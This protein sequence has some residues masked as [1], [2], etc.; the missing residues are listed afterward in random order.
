MRH[1][2]KRKYLILSAVLLIVLL[3]PA[4][5]IPAVKRQKA[6]EAAEAVA[7]AEEL[8]RQ[9]EKNAPIV[10]DGKEYMHNAG[11][12]TLLLFGVD[13]SED[14]AENNTFFFNNDLQADFLILFSFDRNARTIKCLHINRDTVTPVMLLG[15][16]GDKIGYADMQ[17]CLAHT[18]GNADEESCNNL[19]DA[20]EKMLGEEIDHYMRITMDSV[21]KINDFCG[22]ISVKVDGDFTH[23][24]KDMYDG[25]V[26]TLRGDEA[27]A[28]VRERQNVNDGSNIARM[29]RQKQFMN[30]LYS[31]IRD[32]AVADPEFGLKF[33]LEI[34]DCMKSDC[35]VDKLCEFFDEI[36]EFEFQGIYSPE[37]TAGIDENGY[38]TFKPYE[39]EIQKY[40]LWMFYN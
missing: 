27:L 15:A 20:V 30:A 40:S 18:F 5:V 17:L 32:T 16:R 12:E 23:I 38:V 34:S 21:G 19:R 14:Y 3:I 35:S 8:Q 22:G 7:R 6:L 31:Q 28:Y 2:G 11:I 24:N 13:K 25:A 9:S 33:M 1:S 37:G 39:E 4:L 29:R 10:I 36:N 26:H